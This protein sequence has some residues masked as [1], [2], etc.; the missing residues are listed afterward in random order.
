M[1]RART[2][3]GFAIDYVL[4]IHNSSIFLIEAQQIQRRQLSGCERCKTPC[5]LDYVKAQIDAL[6]RKVA[7]S[8]GSLF[9]GSAIVSIFHAFSC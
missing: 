4:N 1:L 6:I 9:E 3:F 5:L 2:R 7:S 8:T